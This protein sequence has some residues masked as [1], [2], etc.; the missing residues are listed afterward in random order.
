MRFV[1]CLLLAASLE[2]R[3][4]TVQDLPNPRSLDGGFVSDP[5]QILTKEDR[6]G[7][8]EVLSDLERET[9]AEYAVVI[10]NSI[11][12]EVPKSFAVELFNTWGIGKRGKDNGLLLLVVLDQRRWEFE[13][14]Y[15]LEGVL[16]DVTLSR[17]AR[18]TFPPYF[19]EKNYGPAILDV[20]KQIARVLKDNIAEVSM[21][22]EELRQKREQE[23][24]EVFRDRIASTRTARMWFGVGSILFLI[25]FGGIVSY[26]RH[27]ARDRGNPGS[28]KGISAD[29][30][31]L[32]PMPLIF[33]LP[34]VFI[35]PVMG[36]V[37]LYWGL[38]T[39]EFIY[40]VSS[41][42]DAT[43]GYFIG[44]ISYATLGLIAL[45]QR[46]RRFALILRENP[47][48]GQ[49]YRLIQEYN[50]DAVPGMI[51]FPF[52]Y[53]PYW[54]YSKA[55]MSVLRSTPRI[56]GK[57]QNA[58]HRLGEDAEDPYLEKGQLL[59]E[60]LG[61]VDYDVW[62]CSADSEVLIEKYVLTSSYTDCGEC[63]RVTSHVI[64]SWTIK[65]PTYETTG[66]G[67]EEHVCKNCG[68][69]KETR[70]V[71]SKLVR[72]SSG[73]SSSSSSSGGSYRSSGS[74]SSGGSFGGGR[75]GGG[76]SGGSW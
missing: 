6:D 31:R 13:T 12:A 46:L 28:Q 1:L 44:A 27:N 72:S 35:W 10:V 3:P 63:K 41:F 9:S 76:G 33:W 19:R 22:P 18:D 51:L 58:M 43:L 42:L 25:V 53:I 56:C 7:I 50:R 24:E 48:P 61:S 47:E 37:V 59:E 34:F 16:P 11:G 65:S 30:L 5:D 2:A 57:C 26:L 32:P 69:K 66:E 23:T 45:T 67:G 74:G 54:L 8:G 29:K 49:A 38:Y 4:Y 73:S 36:L 14:G 21:T 75:S 64:R 15:G 71:I 52:G 70:Y 62:F 68:Y 17:I 39:I 40:E 20:S 55:R 60:T